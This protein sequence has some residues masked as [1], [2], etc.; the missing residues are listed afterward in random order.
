MSKTLD[1]IAGVWMC[2][3]CDVAIENDTCLCDWSWKIYG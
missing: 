2:D 3:D 1:C